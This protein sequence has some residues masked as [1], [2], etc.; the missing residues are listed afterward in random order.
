MVDSGVMAGGNKEKRVW[1]RR[2]ALRGIIVVC[3]VMVVGQN[4]MLVF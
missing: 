3:C 1:S 4:L 2:R